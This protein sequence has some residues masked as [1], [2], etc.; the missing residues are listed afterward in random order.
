MIKLTVPTTPRLGEYGSP[1]QVCRIQESQGQSIIM[2][3]NSFL[4]GQWQ[5]LCKE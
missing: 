4:M 2:G 1:P 3:T 5:L